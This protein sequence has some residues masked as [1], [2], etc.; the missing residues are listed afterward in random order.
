MP[1]TQPCD[2]CMGTGELEVPTI[3]EKVANHLA[4]APDYGLQ[5]LPW[6]VV[7]LAAAMGIS[8]EMISEQRSDAG[9][10]PPS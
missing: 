6:E 8:P 1:I 3:S 10:V 7:D 2:R 9:P 4:N 5:L